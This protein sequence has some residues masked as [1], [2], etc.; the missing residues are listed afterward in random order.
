MYRTVTNCWCNTCRVVWPVPSTGE[1]LQSG[2]RK[3][4]ILVMVSTCLAVLIIH[5]C[6]TFGWQNGK[7]KQ[8]FQK[9]CM[10]RGQIWTSHTFTVFF[11]TCN[12]TF[13]DLWISC[14][15]PS[16]LF[17]W[18]AHLH[19]IYMCLCGQA[20]KR[21]WRP[22]TVWNREQL[23][24]KPDENKSCS[25]RKVGTAKKRALTLTHS[26]LTARAFCL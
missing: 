16:R 6:K 18:I 2:L 17:H 11:L 4:H 9:L 5:C 14:R 19:S 8:R 12:V 23:K 3:E 20:S 21:I 7:L 1:N 13:N 15:V 22:C 10:S 24:K 25:E 26:I